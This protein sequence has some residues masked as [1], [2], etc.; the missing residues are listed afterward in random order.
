MSQLAAVIFELLRIGFAAAA[1]AA[2]VAAAAFFFI[3]PSP[4]L[5]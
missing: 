4:L 3:S 2:D 1:D 5:L